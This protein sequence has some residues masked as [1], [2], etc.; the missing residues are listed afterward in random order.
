MNE[1]KLPAYTRINFRIMKVCVLCLHRSFRPGKAWG[2]CKE[3]DYKHTR[4]DERR[5]L[6]IH[7]AGTCGDFKLDPDARLGQYGDHL[8][9]TAKRRKA[10]ADLKTSTLRK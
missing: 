5:Q 8:L 10:I 3:H 6:T 2:V 9:D 1:G 7:V 4:H